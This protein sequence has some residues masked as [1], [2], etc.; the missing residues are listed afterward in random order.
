M[1]TICKCPKCGQ[2]VK[3][4]KFSYSCECGFKVSKEIW[5]V[6]VDIETAKK[7]CEGAT[8]DVFTFSKE[9]KIWKARLKYDKENNRVEYDYVNDKPVIGKCPRCGKHLI[10]TGKY[11][12]CESHKKDCE[13]LIPKTLCGA[14]ITKEDVVDMLDGKTITK[15]FTWKSGKQGD[16]GLKLK[17]DKSG[18]ELVF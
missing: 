14:D 3:D 16:A 15:T 5:G 11:F 17:E 4:N 9:D 10:D 8:T 7:I 6:T 1:E 2:D 12:M 13:M 18:T